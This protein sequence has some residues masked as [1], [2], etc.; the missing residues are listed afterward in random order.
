[1]KILCECH[2]IYSWN[3]W[4]L[5]DFTNLNALELARCPSQV[6]RSVAGGQVEW[7]CAARIWRWSE[8]IGLWAVCSRRGVAHAGGAKVTAIRISYTRRSQRR[9]GRAPADVSR[10]GPPRGTVSHMSWLRW[11]QRAADAARALADGTSGDRTLYA[12]LREWT[13]AMRRWSGERT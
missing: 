2:S 13:M 3:T 10:A 4:I 7:D 8:A 6:L 1:M 9:R 5:Y 12:P 11:Q